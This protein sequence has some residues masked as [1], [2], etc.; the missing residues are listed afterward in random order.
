M[1]DFS[2]PIPITLCFSKRF[3]SIILLLHS[4]ALILL[5]PLVLPLFVQEYILKFSIALLIIA[6]AFHTIRYH[7]LL[8]GHPLAPCQLYHDKVF[9]EQF[10]TE[11]QI[12]PDS[13]AHPQLVILR[14]RLPNQKICSLVIFPD[15]VDAVTFRRL[16]IHLNH[17]A[18]REH[19]YKQ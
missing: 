15:A 6:S 10:K 11:L 2:T 4:S 1:Y 9:L 8:C 19:K 16:R 17:L 5:V 12:S 13:Y 7:I 18:L 3:Y 14:V